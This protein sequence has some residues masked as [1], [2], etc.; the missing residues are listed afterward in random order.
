MEPGGVFLAAKG[1]TEREHIGRVGDRRIPEPLEH[2]ECGAGKYYKQKQQPGHD[3][4]RVTENPDTTMDPPNHGEG[5]NSRNAGD[6]ADLNI[7]ASLNI[8]QVGNTGCRLL[9]AKPQRGCKTKDGR[10]YRHGVDNIAGPPPD[11]VSQNWEKSGTN[12]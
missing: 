9:G 4:V 1:I 6:H 11:L 5:S 7:Q 2:G 12:G 3:H 10:Q 8:K